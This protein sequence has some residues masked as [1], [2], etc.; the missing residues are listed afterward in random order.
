VPGLAESLNLLGGSIYYSDTVA[1][2]VER[3]RRLA[4]VNQCEQKKS[5]LPRKRTL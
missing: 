1:G 3:G 2:Q 4:G 5:F